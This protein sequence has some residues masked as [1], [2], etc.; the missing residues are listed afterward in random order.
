MMKCAH[1]GVEMPDG[2][3]FCNICGKA[4]RTPRPGRGGQG[5]PVTG[6]VLVILG[7]IGGNVVLKA[8]EIPEVQGGG[9]GVAMAVLVV[10]ALVLV[11]GCVCSAV[12]AGRGLVAGFEV[13]WRG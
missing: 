9:F 12:A 13:A 2:Q 5:L 11:A 3:G 4:V 1:C 8:L 10:A 7:L 6:L